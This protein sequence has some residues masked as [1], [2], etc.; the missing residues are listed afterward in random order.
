VVEKSKEDPTLMT[1]DGIEE[2]FEVSVGDRKGHYLCGVGC[3]VNRKGHYLCGGGCR[4]N[5][6]GHYLCGGGCHVN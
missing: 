5:R 1:E 2:A 4:V 6:K 3:R